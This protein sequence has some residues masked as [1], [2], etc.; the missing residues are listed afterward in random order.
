MVATLRKFEDFEEG[1]ESMPACFREIPGVSIAYLMIM[2]FAVVWELA[3][4]I[5]GAVLNNKLKCF[6]HALTK[7]LAGELAAVM[8]T[9]AVHGK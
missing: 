7:D 5:E 9:G 1:A 2:P 6:G 4:M 3:N 8:A